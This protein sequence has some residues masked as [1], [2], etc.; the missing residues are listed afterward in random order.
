MHVLVFLYW[1]GDF[2]GV[3]CYYKYLLSS[4]SFLLHS[5]E[6]GYCSNHSSRHTIVVQDRHHFVPDF[7]SFSSRISGEART[8]NDQTLNASFMGLRDLYLGRRRWLPLRASK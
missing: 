3:V 6:F 5:A 8:P 7:S 1:L 2:A 4:F